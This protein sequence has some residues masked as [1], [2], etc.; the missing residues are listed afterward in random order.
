METAE[1]GRR[2][3]SA[4]DLY[5]WI[6]S[7]EVPRVLDVRSRVDHSR[8]RLEGVEHVNRPYFELME[9]GYDGVVE[10]FDTGSMLPVVC[11]KGGASGM[12]AEELRGRGVDAVN[13][14]GGMEAWGRLLLRYPVDGVGRVNQ[15]YRP[16]TGCLS[17]LVEG[18]DGAAVVDPLREFAEN[19]LEGVEGV[20]FAVDTH[21]H[22]DHVSGVREV[23]E[24][25]GAEVVVSRGAVD[26]GV[27]YHD[28]AVG[29]GDILELGDVE[30]TAMET[31]GHTS[32]MTSYLVEGDG[33]DVED[34]AGDGGSDDGVGLGSADDGGGRVLLAGDSV[35]VD[36]VAR[37][38]LEEGVDVEKM[39]SSLYD[40]VHRLLNLDDD[41][42]LAPGH[43]RWSSPRRGNGSVSATTEELRTRLDV[44]ALD[45]EGFV[46]H[47]L[48][49]GERPANYEEIID[50]NLGKQD[51]DDDE[52]FGLEAGPNNCAAGG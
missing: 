43:C 33:V 9:D 23:R 11:G 47:V 45:R 18:S 38:D 28:R 13:V 34:D 31:P 41:I 1:E 35:F 29:E 2:E 30:L 46:D 17:Y 15:F 32:C 12:V 24:E 3:L 8:A 19:Y 27:G 42:L 40:T 39:A 16:A 49:V 14:S 52:V 4:A 7:T 36:G 6:R 10:E 22:A 20:D 48:Q 26:R 51:L 50:V 44:V 5:R 37:P 21:V 25:Y